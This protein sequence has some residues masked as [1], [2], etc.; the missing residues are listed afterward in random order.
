VFLEEDVVDGALVPLS[1]LGFACRT[2]EELDRKVEMARAENVLIDGPHD[3]GPPVGKWAFLRDPSGH[4]LE[5]SFGQEVR[6]AIAEH[7]SPA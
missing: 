1:H 7:E 6:Q 5:L 4:T 3:S 2:V